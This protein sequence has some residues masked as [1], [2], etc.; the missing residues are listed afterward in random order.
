MFTGIIE[1]VGALK[2]IEKKGASGRI[3]IEAALDFT[4]VSLGDS[5]AVSGACL[6]IVDITRTGFL[7]DISEE[8][9]KLTTLGNI[10]SGGLVNIERA[11]T[12]AK[13]LGGHIVTGHVDGVGVVTTVSRKDAYM[14]IQINCPQ[15]IMEQ[16]VKKGSVAVDG[17]SLTVAAL[18]SDCFSVAVIPHTVAITTFKHLSAGARVNVETDIIGKYVQRFLTKGERH[19]I[20][21]GFLSEHGF[22]KRG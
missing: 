2:T 14:D 15:D 1:A 22:A 10:S 13:P 5:I 21:E 18:R 12:L 7:A 3:S 11:L 9:L 8:T 16:I 20:T 4:N 19:G 6:T 17:I